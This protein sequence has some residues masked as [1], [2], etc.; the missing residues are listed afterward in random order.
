MGPNDFFIAFFAQVLKAMRIESTRVL[1]A[2]PTELTI[3]ANASCHGCKH[4]M[5]ASMQICPR[6][7]GSHTLCSTSHPTPLG[8]QI[9][10]PRLILCWPAYY[11]AGAHFQRYH[12]LSEADVR[13]LWEANKSG[14]YDHLPEHLKDHPLPVCLVC[15][16]ACPCKVHPNLCVHL[17]GGAI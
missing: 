2:T 6:N 7:V 12:G 11:V 17:E 5:D 8:P 4:P 9:T 15:S 16:M 14:I 3:V 1:R 13:A 10:Y